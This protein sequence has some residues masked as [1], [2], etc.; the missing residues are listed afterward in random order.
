MIP[1]EP[2]TLYHIYNRANGN[3]KIF[4]NKGNYLFFLDRYST[5][6]S[7]IAHC[8]CYCLMPNHFHFLI[9][10]KNEKELTENF[11]NND[12]PEVSN[13][14]SNQ[15]GKLFNSYAKAFNKQQSRKGSLF[16]KNFK[17]KKISDEQYLRKVVHYIHHNPVEATL[18]E[19]PKDWEFSSYRVILGN[20]TTFLIREE[21]IGWFGDKEN[22]EYCHRL[23]PKE[24]GIEI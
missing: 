11:S 21:L 3:E 14:L 19:R 15:F 2:D 24:S 8:Y 16:M 7:P 1:L 12:L 13:L 23:A 20:E 6:I 22:F 4:A 18:C 5:Y 17:R 10:T 9:K